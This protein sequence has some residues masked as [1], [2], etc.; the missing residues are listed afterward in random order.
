[1]VRYTTDELLSSEDI[2]ARLKITTST[3]YR[4]MGKQGFPRPIKL[5]S[6]ARWYSSEVE[7]WIASRPRAESNEMVG[8]GRP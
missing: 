6:T 1:M 8:A 4:W 2:L 3:L 5:A 7:D